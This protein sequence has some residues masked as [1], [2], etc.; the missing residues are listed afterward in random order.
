MK[1]VRLDKKDSLRALL[2]DTLPGDVPVIFS[3]D[4]L[5]INSQAKEQGHRITD[6]IIL[7][8]IFENILSGD[9]GTSPFKYSINKNHLSLRGISLVHPKSQLRYC[10]F[11]LRF[12]DLI[13]ELCSRSKLSIRAPE[14][15]SNSYY[16]SDED[17]TKSYKEID[18]DVIEKELF[19]RH[20]SSYFSYR[21]FDRLYSF[22][23]TNKYLMLE[24]K[25]S[26]LWMLDIANCFDSIYTHTI[27]WAVK[28]KDYIKAHISHKNLF[29]AE[30][31][32]LIQRSN[33]NETNGIP[34]GSEVSRVFSEIIFQRID[35]EIIKKAESSKQLRLGVD[36]DL[37]RYVD[38]YILFSKSENNS[39]AVAQVIS[40]CLKEFNLYINEG[41]LRRF[42]RPF[43]T[44]KSGVI[45]DLK[46]LLL[47]LE[48]G[49]FEKQLTDSNHRTWPKR[50][51]NRDAAYRFYVEKIKSV[52]K[53]N[54]VEYADV[55]PYLISSFSKKIIQLI[56][57]QETF[58]S[59]SDEEVGDINQLYKNTTLLLIDIM[60]FLH[61]VEPQVGPSFKLAKTVII[62]DRFYGENIPEFQN[63]FR[64]SIMSHI[65]QIPIEAG[66]E[67]TRLRKAPLETL[68]IVLATSEF[69]VKFLLS[70]KIINAILEKTEDTYFN[71]VSLLYYIRDHKC[72]RE[73]KSKIEDKIL[74]IF[75]G[76]NKINFDS[77]VA[78]LFLDSMSCPFISSTTRKELVV[79]YINR[80]DSNLGR[81]DKEV[82]DYLKKLQDV[83]WF[84]K[85]EEL[86]LV[87]LLERKELNKHY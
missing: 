25:Y 34:V 6:N 17:P 30:F 4:G 86:D 1:G 41:K 72:Y 75:R 43:L 78:H 52:C 76:C 81:T 85:W 71:L 49:I 54:S 31:D 87:K 7:Q 47:D 38:D 74:S 5:Y 18:I 48:N 63:H 77:E 79:D 83:Y 39:E 46:A 58:R 80:F 32:R 70:N 16:A 9:S 57:D 3:N 50:I 20:S 62:L 15:V 68:N 60:F 44:D 64:S 19:R 84:V 35:K 53:S 36:Y 29:A 26:S 82:N 42:K 2:T 61:T 55:S 69:G 12:S 45:N 73:I 66:I 28:N 59:Q 11:Y 14:K 10:D 65:E 24:K 51:K 8:S 37:Y 33:N 13:I 56:T 22:F 27:A 23:N 67:S 21:G 40:D